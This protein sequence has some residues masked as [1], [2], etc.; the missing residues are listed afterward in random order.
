MRPLHVLTVLGAS[1]FLGCSE[2]APPRAPTS[3]GS[4]EP[5]A[6]ATAPV[7]PILRPTCA[8]PSWLA[9]AS[10]AWRGRSSASRVWARCFRAT[11]AATWSTSL[12]G[13]SGAAA[14]ATS[15][16]CG[17]CTTRHRSRSRSPRA[18]CS[19]ATST[20]AQDDGQF[21]DRGTQYRSG[22]L[23]GQRRGARGRRGCAS[24]RAR[25][26]GTRGGRRNPRRG[27]LLGGRGLPQ[28]FYRTHPA[29]Y[30]QYRTG[31]GRDARLEQLWGSAPH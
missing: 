25:D 6:D 26:A 8:W 29:H 5:S 10:G 16:R 28:D 9:A 2:P 11:P 4:S 17:W 7:W 13:R 31:C 15:R 27:P 24:E 18:K 20:P 22:A 14:P 30:T 3:N 19:C 12:T 1:L 21:C 23:R